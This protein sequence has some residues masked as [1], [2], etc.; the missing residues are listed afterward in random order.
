MDINA[1]KLA[2]N[3]TN[4]LKKIKDN[5]SNSRIS[6]V[7]NKNSEDLSKKIKIDFAS[8]KNDNK[9]FKDKIIGINNSLS[10]YE[11]ELSKNQFIEQ[12]FEEIDAALE[13]NNIKK[14]NQIIENSAYNSEK[15]LKEYFKSN[16]AADD[17]ENA[18]VILDQKNSALNEKFKVIEIASQNIISL[19]SYPLPVSDAKIQ[20]IDIN[21]LY[22]STNINA[23]KV[24]DLI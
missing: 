6:K 21:S 24:I 17:L 22:N 15:V 14:A 13:K 1:G 3:S 19:Y 2:S 18:K 20:N 4:F 11:E 5:D 8:I 12:K 10:K 9:I 7:E 16:N 23:K